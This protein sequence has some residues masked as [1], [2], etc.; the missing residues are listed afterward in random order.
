MRL[1]HFILTI[2]L[3]VMVETPIWLQLA[4]AE[5]GYWAFGGEWLAIIICAAAYIMGGLKL[6][7]AYR[8]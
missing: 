1:F 8:H 3:F 4:Y 2:P 7:R 6:V 5:R